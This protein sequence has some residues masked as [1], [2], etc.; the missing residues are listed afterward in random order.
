[1]RVY[2]PK[3][4]KDFKAKNS[5][6]IKEPPALNQY[7]YATPGAASQRYHQGPIC[8]VTL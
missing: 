6:A 1:M 2:R 7:I 5:A 3:H 8:T 4:S